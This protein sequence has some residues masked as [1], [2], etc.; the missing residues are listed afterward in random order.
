MQYLSCNE[1][2]KQIMRNV[3][4]DKNVQASGGVDRVNLRTKAVKA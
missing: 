3:M 1:L 4:A 2:G